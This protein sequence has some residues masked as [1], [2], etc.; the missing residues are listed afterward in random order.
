MPCYNLSGL[1]QIF[2]SSQNVLVL[3]Y[4]NSEASSKHR[5]LSL[6]SKLAGGIPFPRTCC[7]HP[8]RCIKPSLTEKKEKN[9]VRISQETYCWQLTGTTAAP[10]GKLVGAFSGNSLQALFGN[11]LQVLQKP[12]YLES[13][14]HCNSECHIL[15]PHFSF[16][17]LHV[18]WPRRL[19]KW[20]AKR[21]WRSSK[22]DRDYK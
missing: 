11:S 19:S 5:I 15:Q 17:R 1:I 3:N 7:R 22:M 12:L 18:T 20:S 13:R 9:L 8:R 10:F 14:V 4:F 2:P 6:L 21:A 16:I